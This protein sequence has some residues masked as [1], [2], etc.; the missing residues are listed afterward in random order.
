M[1][2]H[3][4]SIDNIRAI[5]AQT[6]SNANSGHTGS[7]LSATPMLFSLFNEH[8]TFN[9]KEPK[10]IG[11]DRFVLSAGHTSAMFYTL[12]NNVKVI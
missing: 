3:Q 5:T 7:A 2:I 1:D 6:I 12:L 8:L 4:K 11:R 9:P 10:F